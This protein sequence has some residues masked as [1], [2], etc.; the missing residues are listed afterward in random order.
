MTFYSALEQF[1]LLSDISYNNFILLIIKPFTYFIAILPQSITQIVDFPYFLLDFFFY[2]DLIWRFNLSNTFPQIRDLFDNVIFNLINVQY[3]KLNFFLIFFV[4]SMAFYTT[5]LF[6]KTIFQLIIE[7]SHITAQQILKPIF[8]SHYPFTMRFYQYYPFLYHLFLFI[9]F[10]NLLGLV[11]YG[12]SN[13]A[14][15]IHNLV[16]SIICLVGLTIVGVF[17]QG[18]NYY[19]LFIPKN[20]PT[21]LI[22]FLMLIELISHIAKAF[23]LAI[24]L[25]ANIMSSHILLHILAGF[26]LKILDFNLIVGLIPCILILAIVFL[27]IGIAFLQAY[28]FT[29]LLAIYFEETFILL[30]EQPNI[31]KTETK[32]FILEED[33]NLDIK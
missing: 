29:V 23:S 5:L 9:L 28:V 13:S 27:E 8:G 26:A 18:V 1:L 2:N 31:D 7:K 3:Y 22:P 20:V 15:I 19:K 32:P 33:F 14:Y 16:L 30:N 12:F 17:I 10:N 25:F 6:P 21:Y 4:S 24:R 11:P